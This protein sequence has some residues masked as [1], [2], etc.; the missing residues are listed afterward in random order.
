MG[1]TVCLGAL[2]LRTALCVFVTMPVV[3]QL[4]PTPTPASKATPKERRAY[5]LDQSALCTFDHGLEVAPLDVLK[6]GITYSQHTDGRQ[7]RIVEMRTQT[8][9]GITP[10]RVT[11]E[12]PGGAVAWRCGA[13]E[14]NALLISYSFWMRIPYETRFKVEEQSSRGWEDVSCSTEVQQQDAIKFTRYNCHS[15]QVIFAQNYQEYPSLPN[16]NPITPVDPNAPCATDGGSLG[17][18]FDTACSWFVL[19]CHNFH[20]CRNGKHQHY[21][22]WYV[23][24]ACL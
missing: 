17:E 13:Q 4:K 5:L 6:T 19:S 14:P 20:Y 9:K 3:A 18:G 24:G 1:R 11:I 10:Q 23:C 2:L 15:V 22:S 16:D 12:G 21:G 7:Y 8:V